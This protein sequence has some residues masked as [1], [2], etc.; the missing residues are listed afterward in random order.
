MPY[1]RPGRR[2]ER[3]GMVAESPRPLNASWPREKRL[4]GCGAAAVLTALA[5]RAGGDRAGQ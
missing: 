3:G 1:L 4:T 5:S 2:A